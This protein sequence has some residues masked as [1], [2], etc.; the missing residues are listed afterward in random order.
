MPA[1]RIDRIRSFVERNRDELLLG[2]A[3]A[4]QG[5][6]MVS[7]GEAKRTARMAEAAAAPR[8]MVAVVHP[9]H[10]GHARHPLMV[11]RHEGAEAAQARAEAKLSSEIEAVLDESTIA[12]VPAP[13][14]AATRRA[15]VARARA[16]VRAVRQKVARLRS[17][18]TPPKLEVVRSVDGQVEVVKVLPAAPA[19]AGG[20]DDVIESA[21][22]QGVE[23]AFPTP[24]AR[25]APHAPLA[26]GSQSEG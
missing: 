24:P 1:T 20:G 19:V 12:P 9:S 3:L 16:K 23:R 15:E 11:V 26:P 14:D 17:R 2:I 4:V 8:V 6:V 13:T 25:R 21:I 18:A 7:G 5:S 10:G 22:D